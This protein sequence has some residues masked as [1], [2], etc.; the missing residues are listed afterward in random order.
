MVLAPLERF[1]GLIGTLCNL[2]ENGGLGF[3]DVGIKNRA[4]LNKWVWRYDE[5]SSVMW[6]MIIVSKYG[7]DPSGLI[8]SLKHQRR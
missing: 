2:K 5:E 8:P 6:R 3:M 7:G 4:L 1:T